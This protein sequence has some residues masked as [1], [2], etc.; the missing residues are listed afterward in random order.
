MKTTKFLLKKEIRQKSVIELKFPVFMRTI[1]SA[2]ISSKC[3]FRAKFCLEDYYLKLQNKKKGNRNNLRFR[4]AGTFIGKKSSFHASLILYI[5]SF[6]DNK[7]RL[8]YFGSPRIICAELYNEG[9]IGRQA[10]ISKVRIE[11]ITS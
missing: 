2:N 8:N 1:S 6:E 4:H 10:P 5:L 7:T 3:T 11:K 9:S